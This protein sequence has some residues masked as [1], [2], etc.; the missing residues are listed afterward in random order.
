MGITLIT[1]GKELARLH[2]TKVGLMSKTLWEGRVTDRR[3]EGVQAY[4]RSN[5]DVKCKVSKCLDPPLGG[6]EMCIPIKH[7]CGR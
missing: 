6:E 1:L 5:A 3:R 7:E 4:K 2:Y